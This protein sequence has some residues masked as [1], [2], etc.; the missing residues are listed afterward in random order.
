MVVSELIVETVKEANRVM[1]VH[2]QGSGHLIEVG[3][4]A[5]EEVVANMTETW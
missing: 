3:V 2:G 1:V 4:L 5:V